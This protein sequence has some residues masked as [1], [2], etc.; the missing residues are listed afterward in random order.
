MILGLSVV[1]QSAAAWIALRQITSVV[2]R[3]RVTWGCVALALTLMVERRLAPLWRLIADG[4]SSN[5]ADALFGLAISILM[6][7]GLYGLR[8]LFSDVKTLADTDALT[9]LPNRRDVLLRA[10][11]EIERAVRTQRPLA[12]AMFDFDHFKQINDTYG[13]PAGDRVLRDVADIVRS[14]LRR[15]DSVGRLGGEEFLIILPESDQNQATIAAERI[16]SAIAA[17]EFPVGDKRIRVTAS[18]GVVI[19]DMKTGSVTVEDALKTA[20][21]ALYAAKNGGRNRVVVSG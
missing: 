20:D 4:E 13:H 1:A 6:A 2:G 3:Y 11:H 16:R 14:A 19:A 18:I 21:S 15:I 9:G 10:Q 12:F 17:H 5:F 8:W 7:C